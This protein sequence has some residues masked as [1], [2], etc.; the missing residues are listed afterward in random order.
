MPPKKKDNYVYLSNM[1]MSDLKVIAEKEK[2]DIKGLNM[3]EIKSKIANDPR[4]FPKRFDILRMQWAAG[5]DDASV[6][7]STQG[8]VVED[9]DT[10]EQLKMID[11]ARAKKLEIVRNKA[12]TKGS[13]RIAGTLRK[14]YDNLIKL[15][16]AKRMT[17]AQLEEE[18]HVMDTETRPRMDTERGERVE[19]EDMYREIKR[20]VDKT[21]ENEKKS[22]TTPSQTP[23]STPNP[24]PPVSPKAQARPTA[25]A[26]SPPVSPKNDENTR[27]YKQVKFQGLTA[28]ENS[29]AKVHVKTAHVQ[30]TK[31]DI[32]KE[33]EKQRNRRFSF[34]APK[35]VYNSHW[36]RDAGKMSSELF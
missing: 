32:E 22:K 6:M 19:R 31:S 16:N 1:N 5:D 30:I 12:E 34:H 15:V 28:N 14:Y 36:G 9:D 24:S 11:E 10:V 7:P 29:Q 23:A 21:K 35:I 26:K 8:N 25:R 33:L 2:I 17:K 4:N 3:K 18:L 13:I 20:R 27:D